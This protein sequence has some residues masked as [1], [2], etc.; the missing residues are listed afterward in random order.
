MSAA[1]FALVQRM[2]ARQRGGAA[3]SSSSSAANGPPEPKRGPQIHLTLWRMGDHSSIAWT[4]PLSLDKLMDPSDSSSTE[5]ENED[6]ILQDIHWS[7]Q[8]DRFAV[9]LSLRR[10]A[11]ASTSTSTAGRTADFVRVYSVHDGTVLSTC[12]LGDVHPLDLQAATSRIKKAKKLEWTSI[13]DL[14]RSPHD[15]THYTTCSSECLLRKLQP[16]PLL[17]PQDKFASAS[18]QGNL[19]PHQLRMMRMSGQKPP[20]GFRY[21]S[22]LALEGTGP[23]A[24]LPRL[25]PKPTEIGLLGHEAVSADQLEFSADGSG[26]EARDSSAFSLPL[27]SVLLVTDSSSAQTDIVLDGTVHIGRVQAAGLGENATSPASSSSSSA[28][29]ALPNDLASLTSLRMSAIAPA[30]LQISKLPFGPPRPDQVYGPLKTR[31]RTALYT[32]ISHLLGFYLGYALDTAAALRQIYST[33]LT[34]KVTSEWRKQMLELEGKYGTDMQYELI[35]VLLTGRAAPAAEQLLLADLTEGVLSRLEQQAQT[36]FHSIKRLLASSLRPALERCLICLQDLLG[37]ASFFESPASFKPKPETGLAGETR[38]QSLVT[39]IQTALLSTLNLAEEVHAEALQTQEFYRW[40]RVERERQE[41]IKQDQDEPRLAITY[42]V[43]TVARYIERGFENVTMTTMLAKSPTASSSSPI[44]A[45]SLWGK[46][47]ISDERNQDSVDSFQAVLA[48]AQAFLGTAS[49]TTPVEPSA[50]SETEASDFST[51]NA[52]NLVDTLEQVSRST[53]EVMRSLLVE[54]IHTP[55]S[56]TEDEEFDVAAAE[57]G[58][59]EM[60]LTVPARSSAVVST[61]SADL[62]GSE[63]DSRDRLIRSHMSFSEDD[64]LVAVCNKTLSASTDE[65]SLFSSSVVTIYRCSSAASNQL[66]TARFS[67]ATDSSSV[68]RVMDL[69]FFGS[70]ELLLLVK[71]GVSESEEKGEGENFILG[72]AIEDLDFLPISRASTSQAVQ[73]VK[74]SR[75]SQ[76]EPSLEPDCIAVN[77]SKQTVTVLADSGKRILYLDLATDPAAEHDDQDDNGED[78]H[79]E[80][81]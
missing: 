38:L 7:P 73:S 50:V 67:I 45:A 68:A 27:S 66:A 44:T 78:M 32:R 71:L 62:Q 6:L 2:L 9:L 53:G 52:V 1:Q 23:L 55:S 26:A 34:E 5:H 49:P 21:P 29:L 19:M 51:S 22:T 77:L 42:D 59:G 81:H 3:S 10:T 60:T 72:I 15:S 28:P 76:L 69:A 56:S 54:A 80:M 33:D 39:Q 35:C 12:R 40:C 20:V 13:D 4:V 46:Q 41:R 74:A 8:G 36:A 43:Y 18:S 11:S 14:C 30:H 63:G 75:C 79:E 58:A 24:N 61:V 47:D 17:P 64:G 48:R 70:S 37:L 25:T 31:Q 57:A 16:L 65:H